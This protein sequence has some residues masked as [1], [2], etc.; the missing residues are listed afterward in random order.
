MASWA[1]S[2]LLDAI[3]DDGSP[4]DRVTVWASPPPLDP[5][6]WAKSGL[7]FQGNAPTEWIVRTAELL[8]KLVSL[9]WRLKHAVKRLRTS[10]FLHTIR[11]GYPPR[12]V[13]KDED[14]AQGGTG[15]G[16]D[17]YFDDPLAPGA[18]ATLAHE[19]SHAED[20]D[21]GRLDSPRYLGGV[22]DGLRPLSEIKAVRMQNIVLRAQGATIGNGIIEAYK[23]HWYY[24]PSIP[25]PDPRTY[26]CSVRTMYRLL[27]DH[28]EVRERRD[29]LR[30]PSYQK[31][32]LLATAPNQVWSW[33]ITKLLGP[34]KWTYYYL[35]VLLDIFSRYVVGW[36][37]AFKEAAALA[38][39]LIEES[40]RKQGIVA[41]QLTVHA[42]RGTSM[43]SKPVALLLSDLG[44]TKTHSRPHVSNDN[45]YS[46]A[47]FKT[48]KYCPEFPD[49]FGGIEHARSFCHPFF[50]YYN[51]E[52]RHSGLGLMTPES[53]HYG[54]AE[55]ILVARRDT[56]HAAYVAHPERFVRKLPQPPVLPT[57]A[58]I[59]PPREKTTLQDA[60]GSTIATSV[61]PRVPPVFVSEIPS[62]RLAAP[63]LPEGP[64][65]GEVLQ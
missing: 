60:L 41:G 22:T 38:K 32:E 17:I 49:R 7:V 65:L 53:I 19:I 13:P 43:T 16:S 20:I 63:P 3:G 1:A 50:T 5:F 54:Y 64:A 31:P 45:P 46:E 24:W 30:H 58:W 15:S 21:A 18:L 8:D 37:V 10:G 9:H 11:P 25:V 44:V 28:G 40:C 29:Q 59:N 36:M 56:L 23:S 34:V 48:L 57:A 62:S 47:Q 33:D 26:Y 51:T 42:D 61:D 12:T 39:R 52:H 14:A 2:S 6:G 35:Y 4:N 55:Q 27:A